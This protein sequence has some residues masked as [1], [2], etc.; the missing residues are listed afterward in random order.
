MKQPNILTEIVSGAKKRGYITQEEILSIFPHPEEHIK[1]LDQ[2][3]DKLMRSEIDVFENIKLTYANSSKLSIFSTT[4]LCFRNAFFT[5]KTIFW[6]SGCINS[7][8]EK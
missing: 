4:I 1:D 7:F 8:L 3:Y 2:L 6:K 5:L